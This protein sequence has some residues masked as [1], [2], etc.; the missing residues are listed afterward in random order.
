M[1][2]LSYEVLAAEASTPSQFGDLVDTAAVAGAISFFVPIVVAFITKKEASDRV[3]AVTNLVSVA[4]ASVIALLW[5]GNNG[6]PITWQLV[7]STFLTGLISSVVALKGAWKPLLVT[8][9]IAEA[10]ASFGVG[11]PTPTVIETA[12]PASGSVTE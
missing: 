10:T 1:K 7:A 5:G 12:R 4:V 9:K 8:P 11:T 6:E 3:K 2:V